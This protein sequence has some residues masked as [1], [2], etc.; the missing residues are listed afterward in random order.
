M[1]EVLRRLWCISQEKSESWTHLGKEKINT[2]LDV[3]SEVLIR[4]KLEM[5]ESSCE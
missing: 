4:K 5:P 3:G 2:V 1:T